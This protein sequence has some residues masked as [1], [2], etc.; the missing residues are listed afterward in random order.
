MVAGK[1]Y[2]RRSRPPSDAFDSSQ[3][4]TEN[5]TIGGGYVASMVAAAETKGEFGGGGSR[6]H[7]GKIMSMTA[8]ATTTTSTTKAAHKVKVTIK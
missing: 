2:G 6:L 5:E 8:T 7:S 4:D 3:S 1:K